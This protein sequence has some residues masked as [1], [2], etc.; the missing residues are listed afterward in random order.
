M[1]DKTEHKRSNAWFVLFRIVHF[2][3]VQYLALSTCCWV[4]V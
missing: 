1:Q 2:I 4:Y 3:F